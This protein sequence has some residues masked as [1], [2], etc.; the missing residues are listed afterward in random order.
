MKAHEW[1][2]ANG[3]QERNEVRDTAWG[4]VREGLWLAADH[5]GTVLLSR[6]LVR[7]GYGHA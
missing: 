1:I 6:L 5:F 3:S 4:T 7:R 2:E